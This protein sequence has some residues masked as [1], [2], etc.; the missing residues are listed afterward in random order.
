MAN[1]ET[2]PDVII[3]FNS[4][5]IRAH[6]PFSSASTL[7]RTNS[8][9]VQSRLPPAPTPHRQVQRV[10]PLFTPN[11]KNLKDQP[12]NWKQKINFILKGTN[13]TAISLILTFLALYADLVRLAVTGPTADPYFT[14]FIVLCMAFFALEIAFSSLVDPKYFLAFYFYIDLIALTSLLFDIPYFTALVFQEQNSS[15]M[16]SAG[17]AIQAGARSARIAQVVRLVRLVRIIKLYRLVLMASRG[18]GSSTSV[19]AAATDLDTISEGGIGRSKVGQRL[20]E[21]TVRKVVT[22][23]L[24]LILILPLFDLSNGYYGRRSTLVAGGLELLHRSAITNGGIDNDLLSLAQQYRERGAYRIGTKYTGSMVSLKLINQIVFT[25]EIHRSLRPNELLEVLIMPSLTCIDMCYESRASFDV[26]WEIQLQ[27]ILDMARITLVVIV[28]LVGTMSLVKDADALVLQPLE[29]MIHKIRNVSDTSTL[30]RQA[31]LNNVS[32]LLMPM[33]EE[34]MDEK[35]TRTPSPVEIGMSVPQQP[36]QSIYETGMLERSISK[37]C[38]LLT[39]GLGEAGADIVADNIRRSGDQV[40]ALPPG[41]RVQAI[42]GFCDI[43]HFSDITEVLLEDVLSFVNT[44]AGIV[45]RTAAARGGSA[46]KNIGDAFLLVWKLADLSLSSMVADDA[47]LAFLSVQSE[48]KDSEVLKEVSRRGGLQSRIPNFEVQL[49]FGLHVGW[50]I[51]GVIGSQLKIDAS[52]LSPHVNIAARL[53]SATKQYNVNLLLSGQMVGLLSPEC[54]NKVIKIDRVLLKGSAEPLDIYTT[55]LCKDENR[56]HKG[57]DAYFSGDWVTSKHYFEGLESYA[58]CQTLLQFMK[59]LSFTPPESWQGY[60][61][62]QD[63]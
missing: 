24:I 8:L 51:E 59:S 6:Y 40:E 45:H 42:F 61:M 30:N 58:P 1:I 16:Q 34:S 4:E 63:K 36:K 26:R 2:S 32:R 53:E 35:P 43:R 37:M 28:L 17:S 39:L 20:T 50:A 46:N 9:P 52:Y 7:R 19:S 13:Y 62:L 21:L 60:R 55:S 15:M 11:A 31:S 14:A 23:V 38:S 44:I 18:S 3:E 56:F 12:R 27:A 47:L 49:G 22:S 33:L 25:G 41:K 57:L 5:R 10:G 29:R 54:Q 48:L